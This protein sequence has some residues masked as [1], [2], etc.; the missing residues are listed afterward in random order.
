MSAGSCG[1]YYLSSVLI[2]GFVRFRQVF[3]IFYW[4]QGWW[5]TWQQVKDL[6]VQ[7][8]MDVMYLVESSSMLMF[9]LTLGTIP[10]LH[11]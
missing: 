11:Q 7:V 2:N 3:G 6:V 10:E 4:R 1:Y 5:W 8:V 9:S